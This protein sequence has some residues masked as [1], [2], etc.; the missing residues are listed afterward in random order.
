MKTNTIRV[1]IIVAALVAAA[2][3]HAGAFEEA[4]SFLEGIANLLIALAAVEWLLGYRKV[5]VKAPIRFVQK[6]GQGGKMVDDESA[7]TEWGVVVIR[8]RDLN[9]SNLN[10]VFSTEFFGGGFM[11][12]ATRQALVKL[13]NPKTLKVERVIE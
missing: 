10:N 8:S 11:P 1:I 3:N 6:E 2:C 7:P 9:V 4:G 13:T 5:T 12:G